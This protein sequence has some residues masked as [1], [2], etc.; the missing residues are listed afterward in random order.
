MIVVQ[1]MIKDTKEKVINLETFV[2]KITKKEID[3]F[4]DSL[5]SNF[6]EKNIR[7]EIDQAIKK[8][9]EEYLAI[10]TSLD[11]DQMLY[12][13]IKK[14]LCETYK[15]RLV[16]LLSEQ[17]ILKKQIIKNSLFQNYDHFLKLQNH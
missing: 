7:Q 14:Y 6:I 13:R 1:I 4:C 8:T 10:L 9:N 3:I 5:E 11:I 2:E 15:V 16:N 12:E 17:I